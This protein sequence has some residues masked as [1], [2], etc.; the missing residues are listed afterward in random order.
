MKT[1][2]IVKVKIG[3]LKRSIENF[4]ENRYLIK[5]D[6]VKDEDVN[7]DVI[8]MLSKY[9]GVPPN[10]FQLINGFDKEDKIFKIV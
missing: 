9:M 10:R 8:F 7:K 3:S 1:D 5:T 4:G 6:F 2:I